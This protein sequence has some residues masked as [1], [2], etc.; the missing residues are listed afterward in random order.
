MLTFASGDFFAQPADVLV[1][2]YACGPGFSLPVPPTAFF[3]RWG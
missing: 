2:P 3:P 1:N